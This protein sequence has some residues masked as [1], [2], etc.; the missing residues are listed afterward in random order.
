[1]EPNFDN[2]FFID[3]SMYVLQMCPIFV[4]SVHNFGKSDILML[5]F[6]PDANV[7]SWT[8]LSKILEQF[9]SHTPSL[10]KIKEDCNMKLIAS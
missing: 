2:C 1:M 6:P 5:F 9:L 10:K 4:G 3:L 7:V 8:T